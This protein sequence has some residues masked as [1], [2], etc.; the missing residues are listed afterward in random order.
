MTDRAL[1]PL[2]GDSVSGPVA[3]EG[4]EPVSDINYF[5]PDDDGIIEP[6]VCPHTATRCLAIVARQRGIDVSFERLRHD[7]VLENTEPTTTRLIGMAEDIGLRARRTKLTWRNL[8]RLGKALPAILRLRNGN[9]MVLTGF[10]TLG[11]TPVAVL[12]DPLADDNSPVPFD[13]LRLS[14]AWAGEA[15]LLKLNFIPRD[16]QPEFGFGWF[17][18]EIRRHRRQFIDVAIA[19][20]LLSVLAMGLPIFIQLVI[21]RVLIH[22]AIGTLYVLLAGMV[23][24]ILFETALGYLR[25]QLTLYASNKIDAKLNVQTFAKLTNLPMDFFERASTGV[26]VKNLMQVE[27]VRNFLTGQLFTTLLDMVGLFFFIPIMFLYSVPLACLVLLASLILAVIVL[28]VLPAMKRRMEACYEAEARQ[29]AYMVES[30]QGM[31]TIKS[32]A[33]DSRQRQGWDQRVAQSIRQRFEMGRLQNGVQSLT[34]PIEKVTGA[35]VMSIGVYL[36]FNDMMMTGSLIAFNM[37][38]GRVTQPLIQL[39]GLVQ[40]YQEASLSVRMLGSIMNHPDETGRTGRGLRAPLKGGV[41]FDEVRF[42]YSPTSSPA[43]DGVSFTIKE[44]A[45]FGIMGRSGSGKTTVTRLLQGLH[46]PQE[47]I[48]RIDGHDLREI[49]LDHLRSNIGVVLQENFLFRGSIRENIAAGRPGA[50][51]EEVLE[52]ARLAGA[53]EFI[54]RLPR[55][56]DTQLEE[57]SSNLSGGQRQRLAIARALLPNPP[58]L[59]LDEATSA[60][61]AESEAI[62]QANLMSIA[63]GR[64]LIIISHRLSSLVPSDQILVLDRGKVIDAGRHPEL[65]SRCSVYQHLWNQQNRHIG[66]VS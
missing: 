12:I 61:D 25:R 6:E 29:Q 31:R 50:T 18:G 13:E 22:H 52:A 54:E 34:A 60:L 41:V 63:R 16:A 66:A 64:T 23:I 58:V 40:Q 19:A 33:L 1:A 3:A 24:V 37:I 20:V 2:S 17:L 4:G 48:I 9:C 56:F 55:G 47:G 38:S 28:A 65:L 10:S 36:V 49:D 5:A 35:A 7:Y 11:P 21:D 15:I 32:L 46:R 59:I 42:R 27:K 45:I 26:V 30:I 57:G 14:Q 8:E 53:D 44:G 51:F 62:V 43:L 39:A